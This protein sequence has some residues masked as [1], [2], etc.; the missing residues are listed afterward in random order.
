MPEKTT[1]ARQDEAVS[2]AV[3]VHTNKIF[4][5]CKD[6]GCI[7][8]LRVFLTE[9]SQDV[10]DSATGVR[11]RTAELLYVS[12]DVEPVQLNRGFYTVDLSY[13]YR[14]CGEAGMPGGGTAPITGLSVFSKRVLL[15]GSEGNAKIFTSDD[16]INDLTLRTVP[17]FRLPT[18]VV[19]AVDPILLELR[20]T[21]DQGPRHHCDN[22]I[23]TI[24]DAMVALFDA[25]LVQSAE[26]RR[27]YATLG[28]FSIVRLE[29]DTQLLIP[30]YD[31]CVP[32]K[33]CTGG[34][35]DDPCALFS[36]I[37]FPVDEFFPPDTLQSFTETYRTVID[38]I[39][40]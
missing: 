14:V 24:P 26:G 8:D 2:E 35:S 38:E 31:Y 7:E 1:A 18:A 15:Y 11:A 20:L 29:R 28:Q 19:E 34:E 40:R 17:S 12:S 5:S 32:D 22:E 39:K 37:D 21:E 4:D 36:R 30:A 10:I 23:V 3:C 25:P 33:E 9:P 16:N 13:Y 27:V 6:K